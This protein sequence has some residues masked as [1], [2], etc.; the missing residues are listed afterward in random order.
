MCRILPVVP[1][2]LEP[3]FCVCVSYQ[4]VVLLYH[5]VPTVTVTLFIWPVGFRVTRGIFSVIL[6]CIVT[7]F[8]R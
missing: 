6:Y 4:F 7:K 3:Q 1:E 5:S 2:E 8:P